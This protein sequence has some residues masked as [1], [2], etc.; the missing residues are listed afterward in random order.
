MTFLRAADELGLPRVVSVQNAYSLLNR[1]FEQALAE[2]CFRE[3]VSLLPYSVL[4]FG[5]L[6]ANISKT[7]RRRAYHALSGIRP[8]LRKA[9]CAAR[10]RSLCGARPPARS[11][12]VRVGACLC[13]GAAFVGSTI[14]GATTLTQLNANLRA[15]E[16]S[17][18]AG[19]LAEIDALHLQVHNP[20]P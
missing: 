13:R 9:Q 4:A 11:D 1:V 18:D 7:L 5:H 12:S 14:V 8:A 6:T 19:V 17:L 20:A 2:V 10:R 3:K 15:C 16:R